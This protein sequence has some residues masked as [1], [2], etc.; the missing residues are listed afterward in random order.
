MCR[1]RSSD[2]RQARR[3]C[4]ADARLSTTAFGPTSSPRRTATVFSDSDSALVRRH[5]AEIFVR[6]IFRLP[7]F[8]VDRAVFAQ[9]VGGQAAFERRKINERLERRAGLA[10]GRDRAVEL[11][12]GIIAAA[13][14]RVD[15]AI[16]I[17]RDERALARRR[18]SGA[19]VSSSSVSA[20][21][22]ALCTARIERRRTAMSSSIA[23]IVS[24]SVSIT[25]SAA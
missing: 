22:A 23:P 15:R 1:A 4:Q 10:L 3:R 12:F 8:D 14:Q 5:R 21:S 7:A 18:S 11:A 9:R 6:V 24:S 20:F 19:F 2:W 16:G 25:K 13:D 17:E